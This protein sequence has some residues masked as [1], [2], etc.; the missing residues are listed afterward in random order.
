M[1][2]PKPAHSAGPVLNALT[3][4]GRWIERSRGLTRLSL[5]LGAFLL[6][7]LCS[8]WIRHAASI[9]GLPR[10]AEPFDL[11]TLQNSRPDDAA[12]AFILYRKALL[13]VPPE[14]IEQILL[15]RS[16]ENFSAD[17]Y[18]QHLATFHPVALDLFLQAADCSDALAGDATTPAGVMALAKLA[19]AEGTR[20]QNEGDLSGA[21]RLYRAALRASRHLGQRSGWSGRSLGLALHADSC[22]H[23][24]RWSAQSKIDHDLLKAA[25]ADLESL[26]AMTPPDW[27]T[28][29]YE[30]LASLDR[31]AN[32]TPGQVRPELRNSRR[33]DAF[34]RN[35]P[36]R[37]RRVL[38]LIFT[39]WLAE[40]ALPPSGRT[41]PVSGNPPLYQN[42][43]APRDARRL[44]PPHL[45]EWYASSDLESWSPPFID[46]TA[47]ELTDSLTDEAITRANLIVYLAE[48]RYVLDHRAEPTYP[49]SL[50]GLYLNRIPPHYDAF[51]PISIPA[52]LEI[53]PAPLDTSAPL[54]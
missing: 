12:N 53:E 39:N 43:A 50:L 23:I 34:L 2:R 52:D 16:D 33:F 1:N 44:S 18:L 5:A 29:R 3:A 46:F 40:W 51:R 6:M 13:Q 11:A 22:N 30:Y 15:V 49:E 47:P 10:I 28:M 45:Q 31:L 54:P 35:E 32:T 21:W 27:L 4:P 14:T 24:I 36:E 42:P 9:N 41:N 26:D 48:R 20:L 19:L 7:M 17:P 25:I 38:R 37:S 8:L